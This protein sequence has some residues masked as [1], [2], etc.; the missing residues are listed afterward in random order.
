MIDET[1]T[2]ERFKNQI[3]VDRT[4]MIEPIEEEKSRSQ[5][6]LN[7]DRTAREEMEASIE[8]EKRHSLDD[9]RVPTLD[10]KS[11]DLPE[12]H[13]DEQHESSEAI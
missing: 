13:S 2:R 6:Y 9:V 11:R 8:M 7:E 3:E 10:S 4:N 12:R 5:H 1:T